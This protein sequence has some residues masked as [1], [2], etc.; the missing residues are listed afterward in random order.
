MFLIIDIGCFDNTPYIV[1]N[2]TK[3][4][5][6]ISR[7]FIQNSHIYLIALSTGLQELLFCFEQHNN[8]WRLIAMYSHIG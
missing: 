5:T 1:E 8:T 7:R 3:H 6:I 4:F 2:K